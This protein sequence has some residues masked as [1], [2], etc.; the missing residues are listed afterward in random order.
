[1]RWLEGW[2]KVFSKEKLQKRQEAYPTTIYKTGILLE[3]NSL[4]FSIE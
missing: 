3:Q 4:N 1:M 2:F